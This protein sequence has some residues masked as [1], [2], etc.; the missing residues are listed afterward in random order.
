VGI[1]PPVAVLDPTLSGVIQHKVSQTFITENNRGCH[2]D[3]VF[4]ETSFGEWGHLYGTRVSF[5][6]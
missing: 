2:R 1:V 4:I 5:S 6:K 3:I